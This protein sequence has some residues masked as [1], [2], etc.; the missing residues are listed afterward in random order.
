M[1]AVAVAGAGALV[2]VS[3]GAERLFGLLTDVTG[4]G[5]AL[6]AMAPGLVGYALIYQVTRVLFAA[7]RARGAALAT[8]AD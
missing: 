8:A 1:C 5:A 3:G 6:A 4:M 7:D 2:A